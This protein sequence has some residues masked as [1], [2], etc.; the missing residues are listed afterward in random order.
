MEDNFNT[1]PPGEENQAA[2][3]DG[4]TA[5]DAANEP[6][7]AREYVPFGFTKETYLEKR[8]IRRTAAVVGIPVICIYAI[9]AV[10][11]TLYFLITKSFGIGSAEA[12][13]I[14]NNPAIQQL[15][16]VI[17]STLMFTVPFIVAVKVI[18]MN[19]GEVVDF[20]A[21]EKATVLP[22]FLFGIGFCAFAN[23]AVSFAGSF[24][25]GFGID[26]SVDFGKNPRGFLG[27]LLSVFATVAI[28]ALVEEFACRGVVLGLLKRYGEGFAIIVSSIIFGVMHGN[29]E[30]MPFA[31]L[32]GIILGFIYVKTK[33]IWVCVA[34]HAANNLVS[35]LFSYATISDKVLNL[36]YTIYLMACM[37][38]AVAGVFMLSHKGSGVYAIGK[39]QTACSERQKYKWFFTSVFIIAFII[40]N[41][42]E[43]VAYFAW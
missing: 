17:I 33:S 19:V 5:E 29:F 25:S 2:E 1:L 15:L 37:L 35:V 8:G 20:S 43:A 18:G 24:F 11:S 41:L 40:I 30:Q 39:S 13:E 21:P 31:F 4:T 26:Y 14:A 3:V 27:F 10:W 22:F 28:P 6:I 32:V 34:V 9:S 16:Q 42:F 12:V 23:I 36:I 7:L 38:S